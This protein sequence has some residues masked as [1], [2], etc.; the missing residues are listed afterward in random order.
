MNTVRLILCSCLAAWLGCSGTDPG[1]G[2]SGGGGGDGTGASAGAGEPGGAGGEA[3]AGA[4]GSGGGGQGGAGGEDPGAPPCSPLTGAT[5][6]APNSMVD[7]GH[8]GPIGSLFVA[9]DR[10]LSWDTDRW[11]LWDTTTRTHVADGHAPGAYTGIPGYNFEV[12]F[13]GVEM[14]GDLVL[15]QTVPEEELELRSATDGSLLANISTS[16]KE[17]GLAEGGAYVWAV[18][19]G[20]LTVWSPTGALIAAEPGDYAGAAI[21]AA[22]DAVRIAKGPAGQDVIEIVPADGSPATVTPVFSSTF[23]SW[24]KDGQRF[25]ATTGNTVRIYTKDAEQEELISMSSIEELGGARDYF[26]RHKLNHP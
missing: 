13:G 9:G 8:A 18:G 22:P 12:L 15:V 24:F 26:W 10:V 4:A 25:F 5:Q 3:G 20:G 19:D 2:A 11:I 21:T 7:L 1:G 16:Y 17:V 6:T 23:H 14:R